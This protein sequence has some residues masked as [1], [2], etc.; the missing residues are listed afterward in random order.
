MILKGPILDKKIKEGE[1]M[2]EELVR[3]KD[4]LIKL[5]DYL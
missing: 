5:G 2:K 1:P 3:Y 4:K